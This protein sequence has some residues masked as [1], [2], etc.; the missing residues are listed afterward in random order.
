MS[1]K[2]LPFS[3]LAQ[4]FLEPAR[5][6]TLPSYAALATEV[7]AFPRGEYKNSWC[8]VKVLSSSRHYF[9]IFLPTFPLVDFLTLGGFFYTLFTASQ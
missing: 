2:L 9:A 1:Q 4:V 7:L 8:G 3:F 5:V 6:P